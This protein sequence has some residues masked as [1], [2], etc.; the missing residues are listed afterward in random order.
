LDECKDLL[1]RHGGHSKAAGFTIENAKLE[2]LKTKLTLIADK[3]LL[4]LVLRI[5][6]LL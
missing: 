5:Y 4:N 3:N 2:E 1:V 6:Y